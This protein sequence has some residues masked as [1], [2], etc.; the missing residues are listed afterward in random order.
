[1]NQ[2]FDATIILDH[3]Y[4]SSY[5]VQPLILVM[6]K[7]HTVYFATFAIYKLLFLKLPLTD[8]PNPNSFSFR[9]PDITPKADIALDNYGT[10][11]NVQRRQ[12]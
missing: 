1:M 6:D 10:V 4:N 3:V 2:N 12:S 7:A 9:Y 5:D 11:N 8:I